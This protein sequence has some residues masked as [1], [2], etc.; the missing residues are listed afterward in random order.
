MS[1][2]LLIPPEIDTDNLKDM[3]QPP[4]WSNEGAEDSF[5]QSLTGNVREALFPVRGP[6]LQLKS[7]PIPVADPFYRQPIWAEIRDDFRDVFFPPKL[8]PLQ[9]QS[10]A[11]AVR[12][13][14]ARPRD[15][16]SSLISVG[17]HVA[18]LAIVIA[19]L[20][21]HPKKPAVAQVVP[22]ST[23]FNITPFMPFNANQTASG[24]G[25][26]GGDRDVLQ[27]AVGKLPKIA[28][29]QF[30]PPDE[31][32]R[33][34]KP[35]LA[36]EPTVVMPDNI[37][38]P[39][40]NMPNL[41]DPSTVVKGPASNGNGSNGGIGS[42]KSGGVGA[43]SGA[44]VGPGSG[45]GYG[46]GAYQVGGGVSAPKLIFA[47]QAEFS[48]QARMAK[49]QGD[50]PVEIVVDAQGLP[51]DPKVIRPI[52]MGLDEKAIEAIKQYRFKPATFKGHPVAVRM[53]VIVEFHIY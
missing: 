53:T 24:G 37:K 52:G 8:P 10:H 48:D 15:R 21:W 20:L 39:N 7:K 13:P 22:P 36:V 12:D 6:E 18:A 3:N 47:P 41:G 44:G 32:I 33:N 4:L 50:V 25:G 19:L 5:W 17:V 42:G 29:T 34:P 43:G 9:L 40:N 16:K 1:N 2:Q 49:Y 46:G 27:A 35:K 30:V 28:K 45:G 14:L 23:V 11:V 51:H 38:L 26:G 31:I